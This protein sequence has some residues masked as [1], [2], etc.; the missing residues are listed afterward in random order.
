M[1][2]KPEKKSASRF[3]IRQQACPAMVTLISSVISSPP[4]PM[5]TFS[6]RSTLIRPRNSACRSPGI[7]RYSGTLRSRICTKAAGNCLAYA[8]ARRERLSLGGTVHT[9][10]RTSISRTRNNIAVE[11][12]T[13]FSFPRTSIR[14]WQRFGGEQAKRYT[15]EGQRGAL[16]RTENR[17][18]QAP[19]VT[20]SGLPVPGADWLRRHSHLACRGGL[21]AGPAIART[22]SFA[23]TDGAHRTGERL[24]RRSDPFGRSRAGRE[25]VRHIARPPALALRI[26]KWR[27]AGCREQR[28][29][30]AGS[31]DRYQGLVNEKNNGTRGRRRAQCESHHPVARQRWRRH[32]GDAFGIPRKPELAVWH[33]TGWQGLL[34]R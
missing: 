30:P 32:R 22:G 25:R 11:M 20:P 16:H 15:Y 1:L 23:D 26:A 33:G 31:E 34:C 7:L 24:G 21:R 9:R 17:H 27:R 3:R 13:S 19:F 8:L 6:S 2:E 10:T 28:S 5:N 4:Q 12:P 29:C 18:A 14:I